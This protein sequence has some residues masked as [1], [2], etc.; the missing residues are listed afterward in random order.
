MRNKVI[1][2]LLALILGSF[3][4][5]KFYL[6]RIVW[7]IIYLLFFWTF[8]PT[9]ISV[10]EGIVYLSM[11]EKNFNKKYNTEYGF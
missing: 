11:S 1:A 3:G 9:F 8:I 4:L 6:G 5:H 10:I 2:A 7:G